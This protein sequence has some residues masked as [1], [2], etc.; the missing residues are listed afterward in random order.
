M[1]RTIKE[2]YNEAV[3][4]RN[5]RLELSEFSSDSKLSIMN[6]ITWAVAA[7]IHS[8]EMLLDVF[9]M[10]ISN[11]INSRING[12]SLYYVN[13]LFQY[14]KGDSLT[15]RGD[16]LAFG[17]ETVDETKRIITQVSCTEVTSEKDIDSKLLLKV[18]T[19]EKGRLSAIPQDELVMINAYINRIKFAGTKTEVVSLK[20][21]VLIPR[22]SVYYDGAVM[23]AEL[24]DM[25]DEKLNGYIM[26]IDFDAGVYVSKITEA[27]RKAGH[28]T[29]VYIDSGGEPEQGIFI[30]CYD[31]DGKLRPPRKISRMA[32]TDSGYIR[33]STGK[34]EES[35]LPLFRQ[36]ITLIV[37][38]GCGT[39]CQQTGL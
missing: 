34:G 20:G 22:I 10:D 19:G 16:G 6:G 7:V 23:E 28:V 27:V 38:S 26:N 12:T 37:D 39:S 33:E 36:A 31:S 21:D 2:I 35:G 30:A 29:D 11:T 32:Y 13:A 18:A 15:V 17:Y 1:S 14:Q 5:R 25:I 24:Y 9:A 4:E 8:F 3:K